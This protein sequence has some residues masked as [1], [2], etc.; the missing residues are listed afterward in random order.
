MIESTQDG[1]LIIADGCACSNTW[2]LK[3]KE[4]VMESLKKYFET[5]RDL[6][7]TIGIVIILDHFI[8]GGA[9]RERLKGL[10]D[11]FLTQRT[12]AITDGK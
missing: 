1:D 6:F 3:E 8:F 11:S 5:H 4:S 7:F 12:K 9:F 2:K 10:V